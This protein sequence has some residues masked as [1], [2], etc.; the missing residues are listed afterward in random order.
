MKTDAYTSMFLTQTLIELFNFFKIEIITVDIILPHNIV[1]L[2]QK[3]INT[4]KIIKKAD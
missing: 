4:R 1:V 3:T 2:G